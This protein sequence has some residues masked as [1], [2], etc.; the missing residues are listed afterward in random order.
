VDRVVDVD[1]GV[2]GDA[3]VIAG[4]QHRPFGEGHKN[5][6]VHFELDRQIDRPAVAGIV[7]HS[8]DLGLHLLQNAGRG[9]GVEPRRLEIGRQRDQQ[10]IDL[11]AGR[12]DRLRVGAAQ[13][14][15]PRLEIVPDIGVGVAGA[16]R[17]G[18][19]PRD[20][21]QIREGRHVHDRHARHARPCH[22]VEQLAHTRRAVLR[23]L[24]RQH[25]KIVIGRVDRRRPGGFEVPRQFARVELDRLAAAAHRQPHPRPVAVER[26]DLGREA[27]Q[28]DPVAAEQKL[29]RQQRTVR[30]AHHQDVVGAHLAVLP[31]T[32]YLSPDHA[33]CR[34]VGQVSFRRIA[35]SPLR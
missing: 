2:G 3:S 24:H 8:F 7:A 25:D 30:C 5:R 10:K 16:Q 6:V 17:L 29:G 34:L 12:T 20:P 28:R 32:S 23:L 33:G 14:Q 11:F 18:R 15:K 21:L 35:A 27:N 19:Q 13:R 22:G 9:L 4:Q 31:K 26:L 1:C